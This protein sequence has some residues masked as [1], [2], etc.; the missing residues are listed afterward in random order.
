M[1]ILTPPTRVRR[2]PHRL[3]GRTA[4][5]GIIGLLVAL[6]GGEPG[7]ASAQDHAGQYEQADIEFGAR[8]YNANCTRCHGESGDTIDGVE[9]RSGQYSRAGSDR[10]LMQLIRTGIA[11]TAMPPNDFSPSELTGIVSFLRMM[12]DFD[13]SEVRLGDDARGRGLFRGKGACATCHRVNGEGPRTAP[14]LSDVGAI[15]TAAT[16]QRTLLDPTGA[17]LPVNRP[18]RAVASDG[19]VISG[20]RLNEDTYTVQLIDEQEQLRSLVKADLREYR[21]LTTSPMPP[22]TD[23]LDEQELAD[24]L[25]YLL[26]LQGL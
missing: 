3:T 12:R 16:L 23:T 22:A 17:M 13:V 11:G 5:T 10:E 1:R 25:A 24:V 2:S 15:R 6:V 14:D 8:L 19:T 20:R 4:L 26:S 9:L 7:A 18:V 21:V